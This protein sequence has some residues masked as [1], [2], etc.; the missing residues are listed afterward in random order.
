MC[1]RALAHI[2]A[3]SQVGMEYTRIPRKN[4][5]MFFTVKFSPISLAQN[6]SKPKCF[7][8]H[9][10]STFRR[11]KNFEKIFK[12]KKVIFQNVL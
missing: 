12:N 5:K 8:K 3:G 4:D 10:I 11:I 1:A 6:P 9:M 7:L 2:V